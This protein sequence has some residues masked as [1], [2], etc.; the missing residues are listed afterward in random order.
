MIGLDAVGI[1][2]NGDLVDIEAGQDD[3]YANLLWIGR[4]KCVLLTHAGTAFSVFVPDVRKA[5]LARFGPWVEGQVVNRSVEH[6]IRIC[7]RSP[8]LA[9]Y[10]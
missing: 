8:P 4:R 3:W 1:G 10:C 5:H 6:R 2:A 7:A 9:T